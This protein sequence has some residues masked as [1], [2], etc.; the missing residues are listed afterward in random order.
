[1]TN[2]DRNSLTQGAGRAGGVARRR[3]FASWLGLVAIIPGCGGDPNDV[4]PVPASGTVTYQGKPLETGTIQFVPEKGRPAIGKIEGGRFT[5]TTVKEGDGA[6]P[7]KHAVAVSSM[8]QT[9][10]PQPGAEPETVSAIDAKYN[11]TGSSGLTAEIPAAGKTDIVI[12]IK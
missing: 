10:P 8:K 2:I 4:P 12:D 7:G 11:S 1:V 3:L 6:A 9:A 5:L